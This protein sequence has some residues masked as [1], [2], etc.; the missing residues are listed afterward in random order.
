MDLVARNDGQDPF[1]DVYGFCVDKQGRELGSYWSLSGVSFG[2]SVEDVGRSL[3]TNTT[4]MSDV[5]NL[6]PAYLPP[7]FDWRNHNGANWLTS[8]K[9]QGSCGSCWAFAAVGTAEAMLNIIAGNPDLNLNLSEQ[10]LV[11]TCTTIGDC[12]GGFEFL[13][14]DYLRD[15]GVPD[16]ACYPY[17]AQ[18]SECSERC[19]DYAS[20]L[21]FVPNSYRISYNYTEQEMKEKLSKY[22]PILVTMAI[23]EK[24]AGAYWDGNIMRCSRDF[25]NG[26]TR[27]IDHAV[28]AVGY[29][30]VGGYW[31][32]KNSWGSGWK[33]NGYFKLGY[34]ECNVAHSRFSWVETPMSLNEKFYLPLILRK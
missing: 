4:G 2:S 11:S 20:R 26:G 17:K 31:I 21:K 16:E 19:S 30:D 23:A 27:S 25:P 28:V 24:T 7:Y 22:G 1:N 34:N 32:V 8:V 9:N 18:K 33:E 5:E 10:Y 12:N 14:L 3:E 6:Q 13:A 29:N 15:Y